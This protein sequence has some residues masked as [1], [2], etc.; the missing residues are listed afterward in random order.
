MKLSR[1]TEPPVLLKLYFGRN[2]LVHTI[3]GRGDVLKA[4]WRELDP[5]PFQNRLRRVG[6]GGHAGS[7]L[8]VLMLS[9][10]G[11]D[12]ARCS[13]VR[14]DEQHLVIRGRIHGALY[15]GLARHGLARVVLPFGGGL[16]L[17]AFY[18][19][20]RTWNRMFQGRTFSSS[21]MKRCPARCVTQPAGRRRSPLRSGLFL[22]GRSAV[23]I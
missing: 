7:Y 17:A 18:P 5:K 19:L 8:R 22:A 13:R 15:V 2:R 20:G 6:I 14:C 12:F 3:C 21:Y 1:K 11:E 23:R 16:F 10:G 4:G 9:E